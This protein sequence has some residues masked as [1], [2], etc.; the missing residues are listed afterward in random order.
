MQ[1]GIVARKVS[2]CPSVERMDCDKTKEKSVQIFV[3]YQSSFSLVFWEKEWLVWRPLLPE[4]LGETD[5]VGAKS[6]IFN[7][8]SL[9]APQPYT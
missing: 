2:V 6:P 8:Y 7:P 9:V 3:P 1:G 4:I 5:L